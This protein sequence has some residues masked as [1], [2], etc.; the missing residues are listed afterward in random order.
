MTSRSPW[1]GGCEMTRNS[2]SH[3]KCIAVAGEI[4]VGMN[5]KL[6][7]MCG[8]PLDFGGGAGRQALQF[9]VATEP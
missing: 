4:G 3:V 5:L 2:P 9:S 1:L 6:G 7:R 8:R